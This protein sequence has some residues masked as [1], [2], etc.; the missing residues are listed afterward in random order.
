M[1][2]QFSKIMV[3]MDEWRSLGDQI[4]TDIAFPTAKT[5]ATL[6]DHPLVPRFEAST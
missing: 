6:G 2:Q 1:N 3:L 5:H 4:R